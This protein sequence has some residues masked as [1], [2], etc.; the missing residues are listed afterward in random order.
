MEK[1]GDITKDTDQE[2]TAEVGID[3]T[4]V[5]GTK[6]DEKKASK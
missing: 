5:G 6:E 4:S 1:R 2:K 3:L